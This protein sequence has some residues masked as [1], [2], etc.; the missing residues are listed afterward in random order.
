M[1]LTTR[2]KPGRA[3]NYVDMSKEE[4]VAVNYSGCGYKYVAVQNGVIVSAHDFISVSE[5][6]AESVGELIDVNEFPWDMIL[7]IHDADFDL[8]AQ[9]IEWI[10]LKRSEGCEIWVGQFSCTQ[11]CVPKKI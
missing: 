10:E 7:D 2:I 4:L 1:S 11:L 5:E 6:D 3:C 9:E 8:K